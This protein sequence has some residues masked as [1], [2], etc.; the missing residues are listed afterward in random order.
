MKKYAWLLVPI[1][2]N[3]LEWYE[4]A[5]FTSLVGII[6]KI[7]L[8]SVDP[9]SATIAGFF[10]YGV[11]YISRP[12]GTLIFGYIGD[13]YGRKKALS[14]SLFLMC[15]ATL[16]IPFL[17]LYSQVGSLST[18]L[19]IIARLLQGVSCGGEFSSVIT[20][21]CEK[22]P[23]GKKGLFGSIQ[24][25]SPFV[26]FLL[27]TLTIMILYNYYTETEIVDYAWKIPFYLSVA[28]GFV[29]I[30]G[31]ISSSE[32]EEFLN[33]KQKNKTVKNPF[34][35]FFRYHYKEF[36]MCSTFILAFSST[37]AI[38]AAG[39]KTFF[40][41]I[42]GL[43]QKL[44]SQYAVFV[45]LLVI[46]TNLGIGFFVEKIGLR[47]SRILYAI[48]L[49]VACVLALYGFLSGI[50]FFIGVLFLAISTGLGTGIYPYYMYKLIPVHVRDTGA[51]MSLCIPTIIGAGFSMVIVL[52]LF[53]K[54]S[55]NGIL[56]FLIYINIVSVISLWLDYK[57]NKNN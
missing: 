17:P 12:V 16:A 26:A 3:F 41:S 40:N 19:L 13:R 11:A 18:I 29:G 30:I 14:S 23:L 57:Y 2:G 55:Y 51:G 37:S 6:G 44:S 4:F 39:A 46:V 28:I 5:I 53:K 1:C 27:G 38:S 31:R 22:A 56:Y 47:K 9:L 34:F 32:T 48:F 42:G 20:Y 15:G 33:L 45:N 8:N 49:F 24:S 35:H 54:Y 52:N 10:M 21:T 25:V 7:F 50:S 36:F 43:D